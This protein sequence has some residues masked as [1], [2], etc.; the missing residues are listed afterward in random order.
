M[1]YLLKNFGL[2]ALGFCLLGATI[3]FHDTIKD[4]AK[5]LNANT[6]S[7]RALTACSAKLSQIMPRMP[8]NGK[9]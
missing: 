8:R 9:L 3:E 2:T 1:K 4:A 5:A 6:A 7:V